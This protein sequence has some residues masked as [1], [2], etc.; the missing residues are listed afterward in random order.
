MGY[1]LNFL[2]L[3]LAIALSPWLIAS[4]IRTRKTPAHLWTRFW[5]L[6][7]HREGD[8]PCIWLHAV[9]VGEVNLLS[10]LIDRLE[11]R[12]PD[13]QCV[14]SASTKAGYELALRKH[15]QRMV[16]LCP[17]DFTWA[18]NRTLA[19]I[20]PD[21]LLLAELELWPN[22]IRLAHERKVKIAVF[23]GRLSEASFRG[24]RRL[25]PF[26]RRLL[27]K[28]SLIAAQNDAYAER[29]IAL[30]ADLARVHVTGSIKF[31]GAQTR[32]DNP[33]TVRLARLAGIGPDDRVFLAGSTQE[34]EEQLALA[35]YQAFREE[36]PS[37]R[38]VIT[39]R[40]P[41]RFDEV[42]RLL[43]AS[44]VAWQRRT[45]LEAD[46]ADP[47]A[48]VLLVDTVGELGAWWGTASIAFV[49]GSLGSRGGQNMIE[50][51]AYGAAVCFGPNTRN[52]RDIVQ[53]LLTADAAR[54]VAAGDE[55]TSFVRRC[56]EDPGFAA[57][58]GQRAQRL[59]LTQ[60]GAADRTCGL[61][62]ALLAP[63]QSRVAA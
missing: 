33:A 48:R 23:N 28:V 56:L 44:G 22:L 21:M 39:P 1:L 57:S 13:W 38:L 55:L 58:L 43:D 37:L 32:R 40:H 20:R 24:Y 4:S 35:T 26:I 25:A 29:F 42:A 17:L 60:T 11:K 49:G 45:R 59:V 63:P 62:S 34:P 54:V 9:S 36:F 41:E 3:L 10:A 31:D 19:R 16:F 47:R 7:P 5:G 6:V 27:G 8:R 18:V 53:Q 12:H 14:I 50:P 52:F 61:I 30:G 51:A 2:Y 15:P 46:G